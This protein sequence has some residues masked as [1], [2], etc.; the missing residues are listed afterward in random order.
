MDGSTLKKR[1]F[2]TGIRESLRCSM[3]PVATV[4]LIGLLWPGVGLCDL[5]VE[6]LVDRSG[7]MWSSYRGKAK[8]VQV[9]K[10]IDRV[11]SELPPEVAMGLRVYPPPEKHAHGPD[12]GLRIP[13]EA[14]NRSLFAKE[15]QRLN[16]RGVGSL[17]DQ[18]S[19]ALKDFP[20]GED[21]KLLVLL[22]D[23]ADTKGV[24]FCE[25][26]LKMARPD[27]LR[28][29]AISLNLKDPADEEELDCLSRQMGGR[30]IH[31]TP[32]NSLSST[33]LPIA[34][35]A[36]QDEVDRQR[37][38][39]EEEK[40]IQALLSKTRLKVEFHNTL[41]PF[42]ADTI[43][44]ER[45]LLD[46]EEV[47]IDTSVRLAQGEGFLLFDRAMAEGTHQLSLRYKKWKDDKAVPSVEGLLEVVVEEGRTSHVEC[48]PRG[49]LF[50]WDF[51]FKA[52]TF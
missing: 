14:D 28:F 46:G 27:G 24:S 45:C 42:F 34:K 44:V 39:A 13:V 32:A 31:L 22:C 51:T 36:Y 37:R 40:R 50:H 48:Y 9:A 47:S 17:R 4:L 19:R 7:S 6:F 29:H 26:E 52:R 21:T 20:E 30:A 41:D 8:I 10:A 35:Q 1:T 5:Y 3:G 15:Y 16:P 33:L 12:P 18:L 38:V 49:A 25:R 43:Q 23:G 11:A 2:T